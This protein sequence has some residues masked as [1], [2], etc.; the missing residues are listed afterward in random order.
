MVGFEPTNIGVKDRCLTAWRCP[1][2]F[3]FRFSG[4]KQNSIFSRKCQ[5]DARK[6]SGRKHT[7]PGSPRFT[8]KSRDGRSFLTV[9]FCLRKIIILCLLNNSKMPSQSDKKAFLNYSGARFFRV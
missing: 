5:E 7:R 2:F 6:K 9:L 4:E 1:R 8:G 3:G